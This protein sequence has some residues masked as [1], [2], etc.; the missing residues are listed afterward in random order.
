L[1]SR[2]PLTSLGL[3]GVCVGGPFDF[4]KDLWFYQGGNAISVERILRDRR[5]TFGQSIITS[6]LNGE[7]KVWCGPKFARD[8]G[9]TL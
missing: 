4:S 8:A 2:L 3:W 5:L 1:A 9:F 6:K 7:R